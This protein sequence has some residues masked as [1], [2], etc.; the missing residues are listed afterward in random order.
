MRA[1]SEHDARKSGRKLRQ[2]SHHVVTLPVS[3]PL[4]RPVSFLRVQLI[5]LS[6]ATPA[7]LRRKALPRSSAPCR[8]APAPAS[9]PLCYPWTL[10][11]LRVYSAC[12][13]TSYS[14]MPYDK[15][16]TELR[17]YRRKPKS[18]FCSVSSSSLLSCFPFPPSLG[19]A[20]ALLLMSPAQ[21]CLMSYRNTI[22]VC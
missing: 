16:R 6:S 4:P 1:A 21:P 14:G 11:S 13:R 9:R 18:F 22:L 20:N 19:S 7:I 3:G 10:P 12:R 5:R 2:G 17:A 15:G 8:G